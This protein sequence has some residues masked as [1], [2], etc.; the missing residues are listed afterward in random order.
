MTH[1]HTAAGVY[2]V[3]PT[4]TARSPSVH[5]LPYDYAR[6][7]ILLSSTRSRLCLCSSASTS[8]YFASSRELLVVLA[9]FV[10]RFQRVLFAAR[11]RRHLRVFPAR[12]WFD[13]INSVIHN[14]I[15]FS[16]RK[17]N[18]PKKR[19]IFKVIFCIKK[20]INCNSIFAASDHRH[21]RVFPACWRLD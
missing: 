10:P 9:H 19:L 17:K 5:I 14:L 6:V 3:T 2:Y 16:L 8:S 20:K 12:W 15:S 4:H 1:T 11:V 21:L 18:Y 13:K 7:R